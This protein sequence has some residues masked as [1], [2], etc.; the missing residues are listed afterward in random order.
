MARVGMVARAG[1]IVGALAF[2]AVGLPAPGRISADEP[3]TVARRV[4][5]GDPREAGEPVQGPQP[6]SGSTEGTACSRR[7]PDSGS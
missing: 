6:G 4:A 5:D 3:G 7:W 1:L 2:G